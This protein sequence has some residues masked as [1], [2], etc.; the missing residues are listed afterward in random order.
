[1]R[2]RSGSRSLCSNKS[3]YPSR[4]LDCGDET[5]QVLDHL[6]GA[7]ITGTRGRATTTISA[8]ARTLD[9]ELLTTVRVKR[10]SLEADKQRGIALNAADAIGRDGPDSAREHR[11]ERRAVPGRD[12]ALRRRKARDRRLG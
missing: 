2:P 9:P 5:A 11:Q 8:V 1:M 3:E 6:G 4:R 12:R 7:A 10:V